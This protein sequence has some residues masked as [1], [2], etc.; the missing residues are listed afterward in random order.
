MADRSERPGATASRRAFAVAIAAALTIGVA[1]T[2]LAQLR[3]REPQVGDF[4]IASR[5]LDDANFAEAVVLLLATG[6]NG[7]QGIV[8]NRRTLVRVAT[9]LPDLEAMADRPD[10]LYW[11]GPV[12]PTKAVLLTHGAEAPPTGTPLIEGVWIVRTRE[13]IEQL[14]GRGALPSE[15]R[16]YSGYAGWSPGQLEW[17]IETGSWYLR[18]G[19]AERIFADDTDALWKALSLLASAPVV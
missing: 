18:R 6:P 19:E 5:R 2:V 12:E 16:L 3:S 11:G 9:A 13:G 17:E 10:T 7:A 4:L 14:L 1:T 8:V 15:M